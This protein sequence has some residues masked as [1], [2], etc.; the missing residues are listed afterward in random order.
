MGSRD[1][2]KNAAVKSKSP[3]QMQD[4][5]TVRNRAKSCN[6]LLKQKYFINKISENKGNMKECWKRTSRPLHKYSK[7]TNITY[8]KGGD[9]EIRE[10]REIYNTMNNYFCSL[11]EDIA[12]ILRHLQTL[13]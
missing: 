1:K 7:S 2:L 12:K 6:V 11:G 4:Y 8:I 13:S 10:R 3:S 9:T 5:K